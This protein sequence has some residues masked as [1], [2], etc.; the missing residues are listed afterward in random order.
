MTSAPLAHAIPRP[1][2]LDTLDPAPAAPALEADRRFDLVV[3]GGGF[4][5]LW[6][7]LH[8]RQ[9]WPG[10]SIAV[11]EARRCG[12]EA[13]GRNGGFCA[14][15]ISHGVG[16]ALRRWPEEAETLVRLGRQNLDE[17]EADLKRFGMH[18][19]FERRGKLSV[20]MQPWQV[21]GLRGMQRNYERFGIDCEFLDKAKLADKL[22]SPAYQAGVFEP[23]YALLNPAKMAAELRRVCLQ[24]GVELFENTPVHELH[25]RGDRLLL[26]CD[27]G[28]LEAGQIALA[29]NIAP[30]L[31]GHLNSS[32]IPVYDYSLVT[33]PLTDDQLHAIGWIDRY[34]I[35]D[36][37]NQFHYLRKTADNRILWAGF[38][39]IYHFGSR[40]DEA[41]TQ[42]PESFERLAGQFR[43][44]FPQLGPMEFSHAWGGIID[45]SART[46]LFT[47]CVLG[48][49]VAYAL[50][51]TG[52]GVSAS[53]FAALNMLDQ[54]GGESTERTRLRMTSQ[55]P[56]PFPPEPL[57][58][59]GVR[60]AQR[61]LAKEDR[62][63]RRDLLLKTFDAFGIGFDS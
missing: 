23:N 51:F 56:F 33:Q 57:R 12:G 43:E 28:E 48:G 39:A 38:D 15:S 19:E 7:A 62:N 13:S 2:W 3:V 1:F 26:R 55:K 5:G 54:L 50:G 35:A 45:T 59:L 42:R 24:Q 27:R 61:S 46:T 47:G 20:A 10:A 34:G 22:D 36:A 25:Q 52:Q 40:R 31:L 44:A 29:T 4:T 58:Y 53:R 17:F 18:V 49:R 14:P 37:G 63:G 60:L 6:T 41:L 11:L 32:V 8:A 21:D 9:R 30:P 16:N